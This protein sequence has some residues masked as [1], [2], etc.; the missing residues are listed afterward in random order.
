MWPPTNLLLLIITA[1][2]A[3]TLLTVGVSL[4]VCGPVDVG[5]STLCRY[6]V[7]YLLNRWPVVCYVDLDVGQ[8]E[9]TV[10]GVVSLHLLTEPVLGPPM[11]HL[12]RPTKLVSFGALVTFLLSVVRSPAFAYS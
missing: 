4:L 12:R 8:S 10:P 5:K 7:N 11:T 2:F 1:I 3:C 6:L 9:F